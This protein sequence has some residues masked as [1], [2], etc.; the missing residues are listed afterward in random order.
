M[1]HFIQKA[2]LGG[3]LQGEIGLGADGKDHLAGRQ[4]EDALEVGGLVG[5]GAFTDCYVKNVKLE[6]SVVSWIAP[7]GVGVN[8]GYV[9][10]N[11]LLYNV[12]INTI[13]FYKK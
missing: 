10:T 12:Y 9:D 8:G 3:D 2:F 6:N 5:G 7:S 4:V 11:V 1:I 13:V